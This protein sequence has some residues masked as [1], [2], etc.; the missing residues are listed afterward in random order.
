MVHKQYVKKFGQLGE[1]VVKSNMEV[2][3]QGF[4]RVHEIRVG[5]LEAKDRSSMRGVAL[6]PTATDDNSDG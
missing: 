4:E 2:M 1:A 5:K 3:T 6:E